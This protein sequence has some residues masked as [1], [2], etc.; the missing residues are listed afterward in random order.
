MKKQDKWPLEYRS[1]RKAGSDDSAYPLNFSIYHRF[2][3][4][5]VLLISGRQIPGF[6]RKHL[7]VWYICRFSYKLA[8]GDH[9]TLRPQNNE[10]DW[11]GLSSTSVFVVQIWNVFSDLAGIENDHLKKK[12]MFLIYQSLLHKPSKSLFYYLPP[13]TPWTLEVSNPTSKFL[14]R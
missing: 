2:F 6:H 7:R 8:E 5:S 3:A 12:F 10:L 13:W 14:H 4:S 9:S 11:L 1:H